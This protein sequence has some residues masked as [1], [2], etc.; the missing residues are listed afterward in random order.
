[1][2]TTNPAFAATDKLMT[3]GLPPPHQP[4]VKSS[5]AVH[6][7]NMTS[8]SSLVS[9]SAS[10]H[11]SASTLGT[12]PTLHSTMPRPLPSSVDELHFKE[13]LPQGFTDLGSTSDSDLKPPINLEAG[14]LPKEG[15]ISC[16]GSQ[17]NDQSFNDSDHLLANSGELNFRMGEAL[18]VSFKQGTDVFYSPQTPKT[19]SHHSL[20]LEDSEDSDSNS[21]QFSFVK[22]MRGGRNTSVKYY[23]KAVKPDVNPSQ[24]LDH[25]DMD[26]GADDFSD[27][28]FDNNGIDD[29]HH[30]DDEEDDVQYNN[31]FEMAENE[32]MNISSPTSKTI[33]DTERQASSN[34]EENA[35]MVEGSDYES[36][37][38]TN[39]N[40][41]VDV[42][43][44][45]KT[46]SAI[47]ALSTTRAGIKLTHHMSLDG[48]GVLREASSELVVESDANADDILESY[49]E[50][51]HLPAANDFNFSKRTHEGASTS[52][53]LLDHGLDVELFE[54]SS[55]LI[56][57][58]TIG[59]NLRHRMK[60]MED[61]VRGSADAKCD[62]VQHDNVDASKTNGLGM[63]PNNS[64]IH[65][66]ANTTRNIK[67]RGSEKE[68]F[69]NRVYKSFHGSISENFDSVLTEKLL[70]HEDFTSRLAQTENGKYVASY[71]PD[72]K[73]EDASFGL[74]IGV[75]CANEP[76]SES[77]ARNS[78]HAMMNVLQLLDE[79]KSDAAR[80]PS[81][82][83]LLDRD[84]LQVRN[85]PLNIGPDIVDELE[86]KLDSN[87][88]GQKNSANRNSINDMMSILAGLDTGAATSDSRTN[89]KPKTNSASLNK[90]IE[91]PISEPLPSSVVANTLREK[92]SWFEE[93]K[94]RPAKISPGA[95][96]APSG[97]RNEITEVISGNAEVENYVFDDAI[98][99]EANQLPEDF[100]FE[101][102]ESLQQDTDSVTRSLSLGYPT[103]SGAFY[104]SNSYNNKPVKA[105]VET[106]F[107][108][109]KIETLNKTV[110]IYRSG[111]PLHL[112]INKSGSVSRATSTRSTNSFVSINEEETDDADV[113]AM[114]GRVDTHKSLASPVRLFTMDNSAIDPTLSAKGKRTLGVQR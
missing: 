22:D 103:A 8:Q 79:D 88:S 60:V 86:N 7:M 91:Q 105:S 89:P 24:Q 59:H 111:S 6:S 74:G 109:N 1:M 71:E 84:A 21:S 64:F 93:E 106:K 66:C 82:D 49:L 39:S 44:M 4:F 20:D 34:S 114:T 73:L 38:H 17:N 65:R 100:D 12:S 27:Y 23:K 5:R 95:P 14:L 102:Y 96:R 2:A 42:I 40:S 53:E 75:E 97:L 16:S 26:F 70:A 41:E 30:D 92:Y 43:S 78:V 15:N 33:T 69:Q 77:T 99:D 18:T 62:S 19:G 83:Q 72:P 28:D 90:V 67:Q 3:K 63:N 98:I 25:N 57:G 52:S 46:V 68:I 47:P 13:T 31:A 61:N 10:L 9:Q 55:P 35:S 51:S 56:N 50:K 48:F 107:Q 36:D 11:S 108:T 112:E 54:V 80:D 94:P 85:E 87:E 110:T 104:R 29:Y 58:L 101:E 76:I 113:G 37:S 32:E 81:A 45:K